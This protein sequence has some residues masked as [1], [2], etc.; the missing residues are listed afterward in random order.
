MEPY[1]RAKISRVIE[2]AFAS[3]DSPLADE[4]RDAMTLAIEEELLREKGAG[5]PLHVEDIQD[6]VEKP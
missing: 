6:L 1:R 3:V 5:Q 4:E 2:L